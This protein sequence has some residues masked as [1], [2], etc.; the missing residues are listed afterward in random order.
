MQRLSV[1]D[2]H[3]PAKLREPY[4]WYAQARE[5]GPFL[6][7][8]LG[9][10]VI[11]RYQD[12]IE[13]LADHQCFSSHAYR[14]SH[15]SPTIERAMRAYQPIFHFFG[16]QFIFRDG[17]DHLR[18]RRL[19][20]PFFTPTFV[21]HLSPVIQE[22]CQNLLSDLEH[23]GHSSAD[24]VTQYASR[25]PLAITAHLL[26][27]PQTLEDLA[28]YESWSTTFAAVH[29]RFGLPHNHLH[30][31]EHLRS[32]KE[33]LDPIF[34][35][36]RCHPRPGL[37]STL[38]EHEGTGPE[39][40]RSHE[41]IPT[42]HLLVAGGHYNMTN[43]ISNAILALVRQPDR[44]MLQRQLEEAPQQ[45]VEESL[46]YDSPAHFIGRVATRDTLLGG[47][48][49]RAGQGML[50][51][52]AAANHDTTFFESP[53]RFWPPR[54]ASHHLS[55]GSRL[56]FCVGASLARLEIATAVR[57]LFKRFPGLE[58]AVPVEELHW[59]NIAMRGVQQLPICL[60]AKA[61]NTDAFASVSIDAQTEPHTDALLLSTNQ[62][63]P[64][65]KDE[66]HVA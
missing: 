19:I 17:P 53:Q 29:A 30:L 38:L 31:Q 16:A 64:L 65:R 3:A 28:R 12:V 18:L 40:I 1:A 50:L 45:I 39:H 60:Y 58:L 59:T 27:L 54:S 6:D 13:V 20:Q 61:R 9:L 37:I 14:Q 57:C 34:T 51:G 55:F 63:P 48:R 46:R 10:W 23:T 26:G 43:A 47:A 52:L 42:I 7:P 35:A 33:T 66:K 2:L 24:V 36:Y 22:I 25:L 41:I 44:M 8:V 15:R 62:E 56:H 11:T 32:V 21:R 4:S 49:I 5:R